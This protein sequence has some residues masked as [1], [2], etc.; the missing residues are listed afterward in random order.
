MAHGT[1]PASPPVKKG[2]NLVA[3]EFTEIQ[4]P[5]RLKSLKLDGSTIAG[6][7]R[8]AQDMANA[9]AEEIAKG[10]S[11]P[12]PPH[13]YVIP[14]YHER[15]LFPRITAH[16][17]AYHTWKNKTSRSKNKQYRYKCGDAATYASSWPLRC[18]R[19]GPPSGG[20][21]RSSIM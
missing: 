13:P 20:L 16:I 7:I 6:T 17:T 4:I 5:H 19:P 18:A 14:N 3:L 12:Q 10:G 9:I 1:S 2:M 21:P 8:P 11:N 15:P